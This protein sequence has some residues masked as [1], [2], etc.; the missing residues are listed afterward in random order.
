[1]YT[2]GIE[3]GSTRIKSVLIDNS[4]EPVCIGSHNWENKLEGGIW[5]YSIEDVWSGVQASYANMAAKYRQKFNSERLSLSAIGISGMM[6]GYLPL[7]SDGNVLTKFRTWRNTN[8]HAAAE[9]LTELFDFNIPLRWSV[10]HLYQAILNGEAHVKGIDFL[11][12]L[13][14]YVHYRLTGK[15][16][17]GVG[18]ASGMFPVSEK[19]YDHTMVEK[20]DQL[21]SNPWRIGDI[22]PEI[23]YA[24]ECAGALTAEGAKLLDPSGAL[25]PGIP[26]CPPEGDAGT[27]MVATHAVKRNTGNISAGTSIFSMIVLDKPLSRRRAEIDIV[28]TPDGKPVAMVHCNNGT[29][30]IDAWVNLLQESASLFS[31]KTIDKAEVYSE[32]YNAALAGEPDCGGLMAFNYLSG[33]HN[34]GMEEGRP[35]FMRTPTARFTIANFMRTMMYSVMATLRLGMDV[36]SKEENINIDLL[37]GHGGFFATKDV[38]Q[39]LMAGAL[40]TPVAVMETANEGGAW[41]I[42]I[43]AAFLQSD[44]TLDEFLDEEVFENRKSTLIK[45]DA[46]DTAGFEKFIACYKAAL[47]VERAAIENY[48]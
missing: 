20:F 6:H 1:M 12:T 17:M 14:G 8:T 37:V 48:K 22:L 42:A 21:H 3:L 45:P 28:A 36:I 40:N 34:T 19:N 5:T 16:V 13:A 25:K 41:G 44:S 7:D 39:K 47:V 9:K 4:F 24:G 35:L 2:L 26:L 11:T 33:E 43:L 18:E 23:L 27:G 29:S 31:K 30:D 15:K 38:A 10:A 46:E 32:L